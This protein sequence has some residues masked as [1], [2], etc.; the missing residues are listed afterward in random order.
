MYNLYLATI[1][2]EVNTSLV[3]G[4]VNLHSQHILLTYTAT[5]DW[6]QSIQ[7]SQGA[8][9]MKVLLLQEVMLLCC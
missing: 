4:S 6:S 5:A 1:C 8:R 9:N 2:L 7:A 3:H